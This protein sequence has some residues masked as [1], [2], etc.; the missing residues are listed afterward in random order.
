MYHDIQGL[1]ASNFRT[2]PLTRLWTYHHLDGREP[3]KISRIA[4]TGTGHQDIITKALN[5]IMST[6][7]FFNTHNYRISFVPLGLISP[8]N[9]PEIAEYLR[10]KLTGCFESFEILELMSTALAAKRQFLKLVEVEGNFIVFYGSAEGTFD[11]YHIVLAL[12]MS[13]HK[14]N[15]DFIKRAS[16]AIA[17]R[18]YTFPFTR[19]EF[20]ALDHYRNEFTKDIRSRLVNEVLTNVIK[21]PDFKADI[22]ADE[23]LL[24]N[25]ER[26]ID[27]L[28]ISLKE[29]RI[30]QYYYETG[31][32]LA[33]G[34]QLADY[35][36]QY[37]MDKL[38][39]IEMMS[40]TS[41]RM[42]L[43]A[44][45]SFSDNIDVYLSRADSNTILSSR[46]KIVKLLSDIAERNVRLYLFGSVAINFPLKSK[47][48]IQGLSTSQFNYFTGMEDYYAKQA[49]Y[50]D[51]LSGHN[52]FGAAKMAMIKYFEQKNYE[53]MFDHL[54]YAVGS[55]NPYDGAAMP[56][57]MRYIINA[58]SRYVPIDVRTEDGWVTKTLEEYY[59]S[60]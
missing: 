60:I 7:E 43:R 21:A 52:C 36:L 45:M 35:I 4:V 9:H 13:M 37:H 39:G 51:H 30:Q 34:K 19:E 12:C 11:P 29:L 28:L 55:V 1:I 27:D 2:D 48:D 25:L 18:T 50:N 59:A 16:T 22:R 32:V 58:D 53:G 17:E 47:S 5:R 41:I 15:A 42:V 14:T 56:D 49:I 38:C 23:E 10:A 26:E 3:E 24:A 54:I 33:P 44:P 46:P 40:S 57:T 31:N 8:S 6:E 20:H